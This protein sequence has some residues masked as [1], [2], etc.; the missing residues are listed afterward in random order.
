MKRIIDV[1]G[2]YEKSFI[3]YLDF[4][5]EKT[6]SPFL[7]DGTTLDVRI[8]GIEHIG[9]IGLS[10]RAI[11]NSITTGLKTEDRER[12]IAAIKDAGI[13]AAILLTF[14]PKMLTINGRLE[15]LK[16]L[17]VIA[18]E[19]GVDKT[20]IDATVLDVADP[21]PVSKT[22][23]LVKEKYGLPS[24]SGIHNAI[25]RWHQRHKLERTRYLMSEAVAFTS[26]IIMGADF[27]LY[28]PIKNAFES[29]TTCALADA[30]V[31]YSMQKEYGIKPIEKE[32]PLY[33][34]FSI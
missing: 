14:N 5:G 27:I 25:V 7:I 6:E 9:E 29:Y 4:I 13:K 21:G 18:K 24:G 23:Y 11:Y 16:D 32:H 2:P 12:E 10:E 20:L 28:G 1:V 22:I 30:Y 3:K 33:K 15:V 26:T 34:I 8:S 31:A 19:A 17:L